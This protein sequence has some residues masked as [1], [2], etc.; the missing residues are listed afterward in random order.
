MAN[1]YDEFVLYWNQRWYNPSLR[2]YLRTNTGRFGSAGGAYQYRV[3]TTPID[4]DLNHK[5]SDQHVCCQSL[6]IIYPDVQ[7]AEVPI[8]LSNDREK[9]NEE[10]L[11]N[12]V[13]MTP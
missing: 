2:W 12:L 8:S 13:D 4:A 9:I 5:E 7:N 11:T 6:H 10:N 3:F 1:F